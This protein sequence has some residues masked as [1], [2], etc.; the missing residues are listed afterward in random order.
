[1][2][3]IKYRDRYFLMTTDQ[4]PPELIADWLRDEM[5]AAYVRKEQ[6]REHEQPRKF[7][8]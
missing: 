2:S 1:M 3:D 5:F 8:A 4:L 6:A 7:I